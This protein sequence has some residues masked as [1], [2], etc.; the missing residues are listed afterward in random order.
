MALSKKKVTKSTTQKVAAKL[1]NSLTHTQTHTS[2]CI[3]SHLSLIS[4]PCVSKDI[5][6]TSCYGYLTSVS[7]IMKWYRT[8]HTHTK[9]HAHINTL[10][11]FYLTLLKWSAV[12]EKDKPTAFST[13]NMDVWIKKPASTHFVFSFIHKQHYFRVYSSSLNKM[14]LVFLFIILNVFNASFHCFPSLIL[15]FFS[16]TCFCHLTHPPQWLFVGSREGV[17]QLALYQCE[18]YGQACAECC[19]ARDPYCTWDG[20]ACSPYMPTVRR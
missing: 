2:A 18:L 11:Y 15:S 17:S 12:L 20:H 3:A 16:S 19:L 1:P 10:T 4:P 5:F 7:G 8:V 6:I 9:T 14:N 13:A